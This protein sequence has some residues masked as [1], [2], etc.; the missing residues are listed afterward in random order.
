METVQQ[1][2]E[3]FDAFLTRLRTSSEGCEFGAQRELLMRDRIVFGM[4][5]AV[6]RERILALPEAEVTLDRV[7]R[8]CRSSE[9]AKQHAGV[10]GEPQVCA[11]SKECWGCGTKHAFKKCPAWGKTCRKCGEQNHLAKQCKSRAT[12]TKKVDTVT[13]EIKY[14]GYESMPSVEKL[15]HIFWYIATLTDHDFSSLFS[16]F[17]I[18]YSFA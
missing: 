10:K 3:S 12:G 9:A 5:Q 17:L 16:I 7:I 6:L 18:S 8:I 4:N 2:G 14:Y 11:I 1:S 15:S 13:A